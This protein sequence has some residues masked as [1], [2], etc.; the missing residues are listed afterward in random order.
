M[1]AFVVS[2]GEETGRMKKGT[3][4]SLIDRFREK[5][6]G[7][8]IFSGISVFRSTAT[9]TRGRSDPSRSKRRFLDASVRPD[10]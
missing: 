4:R 6:A 7:I 2:F 8:C 1:S 5:E 9:S 10:A 3:E